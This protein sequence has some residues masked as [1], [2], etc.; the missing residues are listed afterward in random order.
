MFNYLIWEDDLQMSLKS[1]NTNSMI[2][3]GEFSWDLHGTMQANFIRQPEMNYEIG[4]CLA[5]DK[6]TYDCFQAKFD[7]FDDRRTFS[8]VDHWTT[9][10]RLTKSDSYAIDEQQ[11]WN[12]LK[13]GMTL[14][15]S[16]EE[17]KENECTLIL[18]Y[19]RAM[20]TGDEEFDH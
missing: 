10:K 7:D 9:S 16:E 15:C 20:L 5:I 18:D 8:L 1:W 12:A 3:Q 13:N 19:S 2:G 11:D 14:T 17:N 4:L 6:V